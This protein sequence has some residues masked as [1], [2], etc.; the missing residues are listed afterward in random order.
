MLDVKTDIIPIFIFSLPRSGSTILQKILMSST[1]VSSSNEM[2]ILLP[3]LN[4][5]S[6]S[7]IHRLVTALEK[8][9]KIKRIKYSARTV[10]IHNG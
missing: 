4:L 5:K 10:E 8:Q 3:L 9:K 6:K 7:G 2:W 1:Q